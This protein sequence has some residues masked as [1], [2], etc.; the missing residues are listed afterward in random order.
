MASSPKVV[1]IT[2]CSEGGIGHALCEAYVARGCVVYATARRPKSMSN[3]N[4]PNI[5][6]YELDILDDV[7]VNKVIK[8][9]IDKEGKIDILVNNA[10]SGAPG[11]ILD[12]TVDQARRAFETN[13]FSVLRLSRAVAPHMAKRNSGTIVTIGSIAALFPAPWGGIYSATKA[14]TH[15]IMDTL[16]MEC[17][18]LGINITLVAPGLVKSNIAENALALLNTPEDTLYPTYIPG[19]SKLLKAGQTA[20]NVMPTK[21]FAEKVAKETLKE[22]PPRYMTLGGASFVFKVLS[23]FPRIVVLDMIW[24]KLSKL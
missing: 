7:Q 15:I 3:F 10:G 16:W 22:N 11:A 21:V 13:T 23:W 8:A 19:I 5:Y 9:I 1:L 4:H 17:K 2:G 24:S 12:M 18:P 6:T 20:S 14:A